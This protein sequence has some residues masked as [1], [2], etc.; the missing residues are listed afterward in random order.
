LLPRKASI[1][2]LVLLGT[3]A[4]ANGA[5]RPTVARSSTPVVRASELQNNKTVALRKGQRLQVVLHSTYWQ[6]QGSTDRTVL[7]RTGPARVRPRLSGCVPGG[8]CGTVTAVYLATGS[9][10]ADVT[11]GR[12]TCGEALGCT[13]AAS[14]YT[15]HVRVAAS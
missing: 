13:P 12:T 11:A 10:T 5:S 9:G 1:A 2:I 15:L 3:A 14:R 8:G 4:C 7:V 6:F